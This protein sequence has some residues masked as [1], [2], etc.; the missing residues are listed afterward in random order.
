MPPP[1]Q[2]NKNRVI[3]VLENRDCRTGLKELV[4]NSIDLGIV[5]PPYGVNISEWDRN[6]PYLEIWNEHYRI[7]KPGSHLAVFSQPAM[8]HNVF[9]IFDK[10]E[11]EYRDTIIWLYQGTHTKGFKLVENS[12]LYRSKIRNVYNPILIFRK[13]LENDEEFN[14]NKWRTNLL[15]TDD[16]RQSYQ[17]NHDAIL[18]KFKNTGIAHTISPKKKMPRGVN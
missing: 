14:W 7:L 2:K 18:D 11:F 17:G 13:P 15:N 12:K 10:T 8:L 4:G 9:S 16:C 6:F 1:P 5:D 3:F